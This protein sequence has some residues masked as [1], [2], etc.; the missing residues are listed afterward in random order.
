VTVPFPYILLTIILIRGLM[1][2]GA[3]D[4]VIF[5]LKPDFSKLLRFQVSNKYFDKFLANVKP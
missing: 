4:G 5:Y 3:V 1:L 2:D